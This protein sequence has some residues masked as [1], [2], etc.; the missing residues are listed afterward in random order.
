MEPDQLAN[1]AGRLQ[2]SSGLAHSGVQKLAVQVFTVLAPGA[3]AGGLRW[4]ALGLRWS[5]FRYSER[6][7]YEAFDLARPVTSIRIGFSVLS[8][9]LLVSLRVLR[10]AYS[11]IWIFCMFVAVVR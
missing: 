1:C 4:L 6:E 8:P 10:G 9:A 2:L 5:E 11:G 3:F 7:L